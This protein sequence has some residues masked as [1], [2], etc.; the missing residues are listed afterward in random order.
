MSASREKKQ[1]QGATS[2]KS[3]QAQLQEA[4][5][6]KKTVTYTIVGV[7]IAVLVAALL[8]W[9]S[10]FFQAR[11]TA[12]TV[13]DTK[14]TAAELSYYY[15]D[16][17]NSYA[18]YMSYFG[19][20]D[21]STPDDEQAHPSDESLTMRDYF[22][23]EALSTAKR[24]AALSAEAL[25]NGH[26]EAEV[27]EDLDVQIE[28][29]KSAAASYGYSYSA[30]LKATYGPYMTAGVFEK[31]YRQY[32]L[33]NL[34]YADKSEELD[35]SY[36]EDDLKA[37]YEK[38]DN[39]DTLD[40][41]EYSY[42][43]FTPEEVETKDADGNDID[44]E[45][46]NQQKAEALAEAKEKAEEALASLKDGGSIAS[47]ASKYDLADNAHADHTTTVGSSSINSVFREDLLAL[48]EDESA[49]VENSESGYYVI[50]FHGRTLVEDPTKDV[51]HILARAEST[52][53]EDGKLVAPTDEAWAAAKEKID[54]IQAEFEAGDMT[55]DSFAALANEKSDDGDGTTGGL[56]AKI[57]PSDGYVTEFLDWIFE[58]GRQPGDTGVV[59]HS[60]DEGSTSGYY[61]YHFMYM[62][63][64]NEPVWMRSARSSLTTEAR[65]AWMEELESGYETSL[66]DGA[67]SI[68]K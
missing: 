34:A 29:M 7:V 23:E 45:T 43:Y 35:A 52:T 28:G 4:A 19:G 15:Y 62:V 38:D 37:Y 36:T 13:G 3:L 25:K 65:N 31:M 56:Y 49:L 39:A 68:G 33:A 64:D 12:A 44:E 57:A 17:R 2:E 50:T 24:Y 60:A 26:T 8:I 9:N 21:S 16:A 46:V 67:E 53:D 6:R 48:D 54:A 20:F 61:G 51:R 58:D 10:G 63:G 14:L 59:Q 27:K 32:L 47:L 5:R 30:Y 41:F 11:A 55:E 40:T 18:S 66:T 22:L 1:R 42:L